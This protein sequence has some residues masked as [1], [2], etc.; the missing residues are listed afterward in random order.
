MALTTNPDTLQWTVVST[1]GHIHLES[2]QLLLG[3]GK[4]NGAVVGQTQVEQCAERME[5]KEGYIF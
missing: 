2:R 4:G 1:N 3:I 5:R